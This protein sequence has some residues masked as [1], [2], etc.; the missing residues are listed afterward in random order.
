MR[1][2][3]L[4]SLGLWACL[5]TFRSWAQLGHLPTDNREI[6]VPGGEERYFV[7]TVGKPWTTGSYGSV[8]T[9]GQQIHEGIDVRC[10]HRG[11]NG[12]PLDAIYAVAGGSVAYLNDKP[13]LSNYGNYLV[14]RHQIEGIEIYSLYAHLRQ[15][16][17]GLRVGQ[18]VAAGD[19]LG[20]MGRTSNT[21]ERISR[22][23]AHVHFELDLLVN[24]RFAVWYHRHF[25]DQRNDHGAWNGQNLVAIDPR[26]LLLTPAKAAT[27]FRLLPYLHQQ[28]ELCRVLVRKTNF[29]W[30]HRYAPL[31]LRNPR[32]EK[33]GVAGYEVSLNFNGLAF[34]LVPRAASE[35]KDSSTYQLL[36]VNAAEQRQNPGRHLVIQR[37]GHWTLTSQGLQCLDL[38]T[39]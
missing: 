8:R 5:A 24:D 29:P 25:P 4:R 10:L 33:E 32:A 7:G 21:R 31:V 36:S 30:V 22:D 19:T 12:E 1:L 23:R 39:Y 3:L 34:Q 16:R 20:V 18:T 17:Q 37:N 38:L 9:D 15:L 27:N 28:T 14:L 11:K 6:L 26:P 13:G 2:P 35:I